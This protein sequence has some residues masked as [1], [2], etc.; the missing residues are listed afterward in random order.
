M[1]ASTPATVPALAQDV[2][3]RDDE[4]QPCEVWTRV[5]GYHRPVS[6][7]N[8]GKQ[9]EHAERRFFAEPGRAA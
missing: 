4:R 9:G 2:A 3:L 8:R 5:M 7:F 6:S 1:N